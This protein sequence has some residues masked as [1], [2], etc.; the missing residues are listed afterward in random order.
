MSLGTRM[1]TTAVR[2]LAQFGTN[3]LVNGVNNYIGLETKEIRDLKDKGLIQG[4]SR[5]YF[6]AE[7]IAVGDLIT[8]DSEEWFTS[9]AETKRVSNVS[10]I[11]RI[12]VN[13]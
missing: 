9:N 11:T 1:A 6:F 3:Y 4:D 5:V 8:I 13:K 2:L 7:T 12:V 10:V